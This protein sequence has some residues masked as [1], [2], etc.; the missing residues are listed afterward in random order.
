MTPIL[1]K[2]LIDY[3]KKRL[4]NAFFYNLTIKTLKIQEHYWQK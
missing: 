4:I 3:L 1:I 2:G